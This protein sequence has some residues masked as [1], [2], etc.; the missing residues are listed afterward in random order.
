MC[1][2]PALSDGDTLRVAYPAQMAPLTSTENGTAMGLVPDILRAAAAREGISLVF[3]PMSSGVLQALTNDR[4]DAIAP[5][6][7]TPKSQ[8]SLDF[9]NAFV[10]PGAASL[11]EHRIP[12]PRASPIFPGRPSLRRASA[13]S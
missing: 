5:M 6:L 10:T 3:V 1:A 11:S 7:I 12:H 2:T 9:T 8:E 13:H 4:A